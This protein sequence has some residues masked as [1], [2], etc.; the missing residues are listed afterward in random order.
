MKEFRMMREINSDNITIDK[1]F[2]QELQ[3]KEITASMLRLD[4]IHPVI[5]GNK[6]FKLYYYLDDA[7]KKGFTKIITWGGAWSN[8]IHATAA[9]CK[10]YNL[11]SIGIIRG[12][13]PSQYSA[14]LRQSEEAGMHLIFLNRQDYK[15][16]VIPEGYSSSAY[17]IIPE[18]GFGEMGAKGAE[19][20]LDFFN[21]ADYTHI[22][23]A[24]GT[25]TMFAGLANV[26][27]KTKL[28]GISVLKNNHS[29]S[30]EIQKLSPT[31]S[32]DFSLNHDYH[33]GG[34]AKQK[35]ALIENMNRFYERSGIPTD[36][37]YTGKLCYAIEDLIK[38]GFFPEKSKLL[39]IHSGGL[40]GNQSLKNGTLIY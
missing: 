35:P 34:Y 13:K 6:W 10:L 29:L 32:C 15:E 22:C 1:I 16:K 24:V 21:Q 28:I 9:V 5:S 33:F 37:V 36:F 27:S 7:K 19:K 25:G 3:K 4:K 39:L 38:K 23:C 12:E 31:S 14:T 18:G 17:Y 30:E 20:I 26:L 8:H 2:S 40:Q 11:E